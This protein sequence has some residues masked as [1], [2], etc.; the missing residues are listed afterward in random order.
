MRTGV[1]LPTFRDT[2][3]A[4]FDA[5]AAAVTAGVDGVF[6]YDH[7]WPLGQPERPALAPFPILGALADSWP[8]HRGRG[9][10]VPRHPRGP[11]RPRSRR[12]ARGA[13]RGARRTGPGP[14]DRRARHRGPPERGGEPGLRH[15]LRA[16]GGAAAPTWSSWPAPW[17]APG[18]PC[19]WPG[20]PAA[21]WRRPGRPGP[22]STCG[23]PNPTLVAERTAGPGG[24]EVTWAGPP[25]AAS[26]TIAERLEALRRAGASWAVFGWPVDVEELAAAAR[27]SSVEAPGPGEREPGS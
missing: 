19:G 16:G 6:C 27:A 26:P 15:P 14:R 23:T 21:A 18:S 24:L 22:P 10:P 17:R 12:R 1:V 20:G 8:V 11:G 25:P 13:V 5:A 7:I 3:D 9:G 4:A 2:P